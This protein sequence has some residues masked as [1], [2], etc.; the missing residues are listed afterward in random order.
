MTYWVGVD[1]AGYGPNLGPLVMTAVVV[2]NDGETR[3]DLWGELGGR[4]V[5]AGGAEAGDVAGVRSGRLV[6]DDSKRVYGPGK[7]RAGLAAGLIC[8]LDELGAAVPDQ[9]AALLERF[10]G[11]DHEL[12]RWSGPA[13]D[14]PALGELCLAELTEVREA[15]PF[16]GGGWEWL[17]A[18]WDVV[19]PRR[20]NA[21]LD[22]SATKAAAHFAVFAG[23]LQSVITRWGSDA[24]PERWCIL[25]DK[26]GGRNYYLDLLL[27]WFPESWIDRGEEGPERSWYEIRQGRRRVIV[28][29]RA[30]ADGA[31]GLV[32]LAS[33][34]SKL[35]RELW[36]DVF[37][38]FWLAEVPGLKPT[39]GYP[40]DAARF[41]RAI[42]DRARELGHDRATW[43]RAK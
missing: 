25:A 5:R 37:N 34:L 4:V 20:F 12:E 17:G 36:M 10:G 23:L 38:R 30:K 1:E 28:E 16:R 39:A 33:M 14:L 22:R 27:E 35:A 8:L 18:R 43:W 13:G 32:A 26:H 11:P 7:S 3:P 21:L 24:Q 2:R 6:V 41:A 29:F 42:E 31:C 15:F 40:V 9:V 19:G